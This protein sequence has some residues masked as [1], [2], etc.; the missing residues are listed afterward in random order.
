MH[1]DRAKLWQMSPVIESE[2][3]FGAVLNAA[4]V[5]VSTHTAPK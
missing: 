3:A 5:A 2:I 1:H 4:S